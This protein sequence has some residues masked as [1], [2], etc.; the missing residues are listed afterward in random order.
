MIDDGVANALKRIVVEV[1][2]RA[3]DNA[4]VVAQFR[5][6]EQRRAISDF[7]VV[8][9]HEHGLRQEPV[10]R[11]EF[12][13]QRLA[14]GRGDGPRRVARQAE[15]K[16]TLFALHRRRNRGQRLDKHVRGRLASQ[17]HLV[18]IPETALGDDR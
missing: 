1:E 12:Q 3:L 16:R 15:R 13:C 14:V 7:D 10:E 17:E 9:L 2:L 4:R 11:R 18:G 5:T 6:C 8:R